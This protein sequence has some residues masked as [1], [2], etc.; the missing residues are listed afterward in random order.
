MRP[1]KGRSDP[2]QSISSTLAVH[3]CAYLF[4]GFFII[5]N[6]GH[7]YV[8]GIGN[9]YSFVIGNKGFIMLITHRCAV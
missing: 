7:L 4:L 2:A 3:L 6:A 1:I 8:P 5:H 9:S